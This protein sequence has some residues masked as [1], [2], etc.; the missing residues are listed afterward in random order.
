VIAAHTDSVRTTQVD[1][2]N[3]R[4]N[5]TVSVNAS[6]DTHCCNHGWDDDN[7]PVTSAAAVGTVVA[8]TTAVVG[9]MVC[10]VPPGCVSVNCGAMVCAQRDAIGY[11]RTGIA[12]RRGESTVL[13]VVEA[14]GEEPKSGARCRR[15]VPG[16]PG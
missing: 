8:V 12:V 15:T 4:R 3:V 9:S 2:V 16:A 10:S 6:G 5:V 7:H 11:A 14:G 13:I 1:S